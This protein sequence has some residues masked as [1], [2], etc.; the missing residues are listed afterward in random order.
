MK[1]I[2]LLAA[3][4]MFAGASF[5]APCDGHKDK[6]S[7][8]KTTKENCKEKSCCKKGSTASKDS[9]STKTETAKK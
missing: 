9:K 2:L 3:G 5:A 8:S 6:T 1:K 4:L 7:C